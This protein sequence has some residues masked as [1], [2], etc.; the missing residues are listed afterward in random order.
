MRTRRLTLAKE[1]LAELRTD[2]LLD[3]VGGQGA[4]TPVVQC[5]R[6]LTSQIVNCYTVLKPCTTV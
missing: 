3:V 1:T 6:D 5:V 4:I 2:E